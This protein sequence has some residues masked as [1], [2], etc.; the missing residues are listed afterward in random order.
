M[1]TTT[2]CLV[3]K[4]YI[5][6]L[7]FFLWFCWNLLKAYKR[8]KWEIYCTQSLLKHYASLTVELSFC[9]FLCPR[10]FVVFFVF[11]YLLLLSLLFGCFFL[12]DLL[13]PLKHLLLQLVLFPFHFG[14]IDDIDQWSL[15]INLYDPIKTISW[16]CLVF[17]FMNECWPS[18]W[19]LPFSEIAYSDPFIHWCSTYFIAL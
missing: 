16:F 13:I 2:Y 6:S 18:F 15:T 17:H 1:N 10:I 9:K 5:A 11:Y 14:N 4:I 8:C 12:F 7:L 19:H 3:I